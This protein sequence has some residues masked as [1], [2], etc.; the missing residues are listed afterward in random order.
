M[1]GNQDE[2]EEDE[3]DEEDKTLIELDD[4]DDNDRE[5]LMQ[6]LKQEYDKNPD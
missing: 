1:H 3:E 4:L 5:M 2:D 6:Y